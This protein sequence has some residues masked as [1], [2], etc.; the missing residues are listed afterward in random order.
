VAIELAPDC[1][2]IDGAFDDI[3]MLWQSPTGEPISD[4]L[5]LMRVEGQ[6]GSGYVTYW[7]PPPPQR[8]VDARRSIAKFIRERIAATRYADKPLDTD[9]QVMRAHPEYPAVVEWKAVAKSFDTKK[10]SKVRWVSTTT[11]EWARDWLRAGSEPSVLWCGGVEFADRLSRE[12]RIP[13]YGPEGKEVRTGADLH[14]AD[15]RKTPRMICSW[16]ACREGQNLQQW[17]RQGIIQ[18]P[19]SAEALEQIFGRGHRQGQTDAVRVT[20]LATSGGT[21]DGFAAAI[22]EAEFTRDT[23]VHTQKILRATIEPLPVPPNTLRWLTR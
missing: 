18:P 22:S 7:D 23:S 10:H 14:S 11:L 12:T 15:A 13:Y 17:R 5:S 3:R 8:W 4:P 20:I 1:P 16:H 6:C 9:A 2:V 21:L 19:Q